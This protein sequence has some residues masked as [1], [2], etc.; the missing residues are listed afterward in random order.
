MGE[1]RDGEHEP[2]TLQHWCDNHCPKRWESEGGMP[3]CICEYENDD[4]EDD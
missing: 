1:L 3:S 4:Y 2:C